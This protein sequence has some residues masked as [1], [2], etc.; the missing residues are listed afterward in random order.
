[1]RMTVSSIAAVLAIAACDGY[2]GMP[3]AETSH[4][5]TIATEYASVPATAWRDAGGGAVFRELHTELSH[6]WSV[7][8]LPGGD[9][10]ITLREGKLLRIDAHGRRHEISG[11]PEV[12]AQG[13]GGLLDIA[14]APDFAVS[15]RVYLSFAEADAQGL[16]G[17]AVGFGELQGNQLRDFRVIYR[18]LPKLGG[19]MHFGSRLVFDRDGM[20]WISQGERNQKELAQDLEVLQ[21]KIVRLHADGAMPGDNPFASG[22]G[23]RRTIWSFG[24]RNVQAMAMDPRTGKVWAAEHGPRGGDEI[25]VLQ[26]GKNYGWPIASFGMDYATGRPYPQ[27]QAAYI[28][29]TEPPHHVWMKSPGVSGMAFVV[30]RP[31]HAWNNS[32]LVGALAD[33]SLIRLTLDGDKVTEAERLLTDS[34]WRIRDVRV[35]AAGRILVLTDEDDGRLLEIVPNR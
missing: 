12:F 29:G 15:H 34:G 32:L 23:V 27:T 25:N 24:H 5:K 19:G 28:A 35:T 31:E 6:P 33:K 1:M 17:T 10:L 22:V 21:G 8:E 3:A 4:G 30:N 14:V 18:Q 2:A 16:A 9:L 7:A 26:A 13:Q 11:T 20:L